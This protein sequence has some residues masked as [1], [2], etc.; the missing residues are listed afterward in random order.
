MLYF[1]WGTGWSNLGTDLYRYDALR[2]RVT[3]NHNPHDRV[4]SIAFNPSNPKV[5][6]LGLAEES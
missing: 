4:T 5:M 1:A 2:G 3:I 6:Y